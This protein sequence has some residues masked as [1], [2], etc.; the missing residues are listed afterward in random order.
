MGSLFSSLTKIKDKAVAAAVVASGAA[1]PGPQAHNNYLLNVVACNIQKKKHYETDLPEV[2]DFAQ[3]VVTSPSPYPHNHHL[4]HTTDTTTTLSEYTHTHTHTHTDP[5]ARKHTYE[6][7][8][9]LKGTLFPSLQCHGPPTRSFHLCN[10]MGHRTHSAACHPL[11]HWLTDARPSQQ[12]YASVVDT[13]SAS[14]HRFADR[15]QYT[16][17]ELGRLPLLVG[18]SGPATTGRVAV[19]AV[20]DSISQEGAA[21]YTPVMYVDAIAS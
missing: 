18:Q 13:T 7:G 8:S 4:R 6:H 21:A 15:W 16:V 2:L 19:A 9:T 17:N 1:N 3:E 5:Y 14:V 12:V 10:A 20:V 11:G